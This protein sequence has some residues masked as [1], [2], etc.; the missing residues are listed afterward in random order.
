[1]S[2]NQELKEIARHLKDISQSQK[3]QIRILKALNHN[4]LELFA[5]PSDSVKPAPT[6]Y[7]PV[8]VPPLEAGKVYG[9]SM[10]A[11]VQ[12]ESSSSNLMSPV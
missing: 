7:T 4:L 10:A 11:L 3:D 5:K 8:E 12:R 2:D 9:W 1:M 6:E